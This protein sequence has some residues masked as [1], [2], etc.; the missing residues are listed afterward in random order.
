VSFST[1]APT[2]LRQPRNWKRKFVSKEKFTNAAPAREKN[3]LERYSRV[4]ISVYHEDK[5]IHKHDHI[6]EQKRGEQ[7]TEMCNTNDDE[8]ASQTASALIL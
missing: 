3:K 5:R 4:R 6:G 1:D 8:G 7:S 2:L